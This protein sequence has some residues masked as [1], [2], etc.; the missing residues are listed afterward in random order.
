MAAAAS[1]FGVSAEAME[2]RLY[3]CGFVGDPRL[4]TK[5]TML[6]LT[7]T[8]SMLG[9]AVGNAADTTHQPSESADHV[10]GRDGQDRRRAIRSRGPQ[11]DR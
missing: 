11:L 2:W 8:A 3:N 7:A 1:R 10:P 6:R 5:P 9:H 4:P